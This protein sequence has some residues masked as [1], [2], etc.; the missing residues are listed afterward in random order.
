M[1]ARTAIAFAAVA[2][3]AGGAGI[4]A[5]LSRHDPKVPF[6]R[7][8]APKPAP[9]LQFEDAS[10]RT[11]TLADFRGKVVLL[12]IWATWCAP[13]REEMPALDQL[14]AK[15][16][17]PKFEVVAVSVDQ[18]GPE[19]ARRFYADVGIRSLA[20]YIDRNAKAAFQIDV[21]GLPATLLIDAEGR[22]IGRHLGAAKWDSDEVIDALRRRARVN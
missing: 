5:A 7:S 15:L 16:G 21:P 6:T 12:N 20:F 11:R 10:G 2:L 3:V 1:K 17:G 22:E 8:T 13:C 19:V 18:Q 9:Q 4:F 14:Q